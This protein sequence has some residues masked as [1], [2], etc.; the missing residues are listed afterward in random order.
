MVDSLF[1]SH[2]EDDASAIDCLEEHCFVTMFTSWHLERI[3]KQPQSN[4]KLSY[5]L[6][7][8]RKPQFHS[9]P[10]LVNS[11]PL[12]TQTSTKMS[13]PSNIVGGREANLNNSSSPA[14]IS[15]VCLFINISWSLQRPSSTPAKFS[16]RSLMVVALTPAT[17][18]RARIQAMCWCSSTINYVFY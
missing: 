4:F 11:N 9:I 8:H 6:L 16:T 10:K 17:P 1:F 5:H 7:I 12:T 2:S 18:W 3:Y 15:F 13:N 14:A